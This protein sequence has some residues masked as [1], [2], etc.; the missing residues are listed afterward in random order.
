MLQAL[1]GHPDFKPDDIKDTRFH[2]IEEELCGRS[3]RNNW[4]QERGWRK[5]ELYI[6]IPTNVTDVRFGFGL[7]GI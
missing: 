6:G 1:I 7:G 3:S 4:E 2:Q 5:S